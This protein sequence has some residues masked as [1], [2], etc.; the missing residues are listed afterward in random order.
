MTLMM[1]DELRATA[2]EMNDSDAVI[3]QT[4]GRGVYGMWCVWDAVSC[5]RGGVVRARRER[6]NGRVI[7]VS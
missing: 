5:E 7:R 3:R 2:H 4:T 1:E 6:G